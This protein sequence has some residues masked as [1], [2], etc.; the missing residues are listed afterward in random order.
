MEFWYLLGSWL[1]AW[2][3]KDEILIFVYIYICWVHVRPFPGCFSFLNHTLQAWW[4]VGMWWTRR[5]TST[6]NLTTVHP[7]GMEPTVAECFIHRK[8]WEWLT[9]IIPPKID[10]LLKIA[11]FVGPLLPHSWVVITSWIFSQ[12]LPWSPKAK[13]FHHPVP[14]CLAQGENCYWEGDAPTIKWVTHF[15]YGDPYCS[16]TIQWWVPIPRIVTTNPQSIDIHCIARGKPCRA[17]VWDPRGVFRVFLGGGHFLHYSC[18]PSS[19]WVGRQP[20]L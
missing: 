3:V 13:I 6:S 19:G 15:P 18:H 8:P 12:S 2:R 10:G 4:R 9:I 14:M 7:L 5:T 16:W 17:I 1:I 11:K 20:K